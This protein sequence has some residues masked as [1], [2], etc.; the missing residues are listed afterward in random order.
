M[1]WNIL[2]E[3]RKGI[4]KGENIILISREICENNNLVKIEYFHLL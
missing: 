3:D 4:S 1:D 2:E